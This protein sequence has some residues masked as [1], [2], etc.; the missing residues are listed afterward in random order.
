[1]SISMFSDM[2]HRTFKNGDMEHND[3]SK[4]NRA[5]LPFLKFDR[6]TPC[7]HPP[8]L[9]WRAPFVINPIL[10]CSARG[11][12]II[13]NPMNRRWLNSWTDQVIVGMPLRQNGQ[14]LNV[15]VFVTVPSVTVY[16][17]FLGWSVS[18]NK[19][20]LFSRSWPFESMRWPL[21]LFFLNY[22]CLY[23]VGISHR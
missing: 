18:L 17:T 8:P 6:A 11:D 10:R 2:Q 21:T 15:A 12:V 1:M 20:W 13:L 3:S 23:C 4:F 5:I 14:W 19:L 7:R 16:F 9:Q 22:N